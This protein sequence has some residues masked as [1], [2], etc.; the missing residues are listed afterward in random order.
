MHLLKVLK[1]AQSKAKVTKK[2]AVPTCWRFPIFFFGR[3]VENG[4][5][6]TSVFVGEDM[7][8]SIHIKRRLS[9]SYIL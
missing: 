7:F 8:S 3:S 6:L 5:G 9:S 2:S 1:I 4:D